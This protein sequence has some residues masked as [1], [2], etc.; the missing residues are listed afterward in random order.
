MQN[1]Y[2][3]IL[4]I[5]SVIINLFLA[6]VVDANHFIHCLCKSQEKS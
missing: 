2:L 6:S 3:S 5:D 4:I 1:I